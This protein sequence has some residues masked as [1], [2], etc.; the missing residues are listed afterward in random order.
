[1]AHSDPIVDG[2]ILAA[3]LDLDYD[4]FDTEL[5]Q[6]AHAADDL[7]RSLLRPNVLAQGIPDPIKEAGISVGTEIWQARYATGGQPVA[8]DFSP[9]PYRLSVWITRR[10]HALLGPYID[11][12][13][14]I[15]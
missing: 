10:V 11:V 7:V 12:R 5:D 9:A 1:V 14:M 4:E 15:G 6:V 2:Q 8:V 13:G 3:V